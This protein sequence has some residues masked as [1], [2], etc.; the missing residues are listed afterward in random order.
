MLKSSYKPSSLAI[1]PWNGVQ[2]LSIAV[3]ATIGLDFVIAFLSGL[4]LNLFDLEI[5]ADSVLINFGFY[6]L[7]S[8]ASIGLVSLFIKKRM[9]S[10]FAALGLKK[11][12]IPQAIL[13]IIIASISLIVMTTV[14]YTA[15][16][17]LVP[18]VNLEQEQDTAFHDASGGAE[19]GMAF[20]ALVIVA[21]FAEELIFR[22]FMLPAF[23]QRFGFLAGALITSLLF[24]L[25]HLQV[26]VGIL[27][28][29]MGMLLAWLYKKTGSLWPAI[30]FHSLKNLV[31]FLIIF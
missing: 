18:G 15:V 19:L 16:E 3:L 21:P 2:A 30:L 6:G 14:A 23:A 29:L 8:L 11:F 22:G 17:K 13:L 31:A 20:F 4:L 12:K 7:T 26:N 9:K 1:V 10:N 28:F 5:N 25:A 27:T 24:G